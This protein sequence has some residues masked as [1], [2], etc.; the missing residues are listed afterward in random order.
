MN[1][2]ILLVPQNFDLKLNNLFLTRKYLRKNHNSQEGGRIQEPNLS[3]LLLQYIFDWFRLF[4]WCMQHQWFNIAAKKESA[5]LLCSASKTIPF[6]PDQGIPM[7]KCQMKSSVENK[8][9]S[10]S[11]LTLTLAFILMQTHLLLPS[12]S[13]DKLQWRQKYDWKCNL[14]LFPISHWKRWE[15][16]TSW[17]HLSNIINKSILARTARF[18]LQGGKVSL[19]QVG[20]K[21]RRQCCP[22]ERE[23]VRENS[24]KQISNHKNIKE[25]K[26]MNRKVKSLTSI[27]NFG[28]LQ[29]SAV[30]MGKKKHI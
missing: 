13:Y 8:Y 10:S 24:W 26:Y 19:Q 7:C 23:F 29:E 30:W 21:I 18:N 11:N 17:K 16:L 4:N 2:I 22:L 27:H 6:S 28:W 12:C 25:C 9:P 14:Q 1:R 3:S 5:L 20:M 15:L